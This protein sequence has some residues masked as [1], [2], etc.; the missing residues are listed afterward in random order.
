MD[1]R[2]TAGRLLVGLASLAIVGGCAAGSTP[3]ASLTPSPSPAPVAPTASPSPSPLD[4]PSP[5]PSAPARPISDLAWQDIGT[6]PAPGNEIQ[7]AAGF[8]R[9]Y[10]AVERGSSS[11]WFSADGRT[12]REVELPF[13]VTND[14]YGSPLEAGANA[15]TTNGTQVLVVGGYSHE[16][17]RAPEGASTGGGPDCPLYPIAWVSDDGVTWESADPG[18][19]PPEPS[20]YDQGSEF[21]AAWPVP[22]GGWDAALSF[23]EGES[24][25]GRDLW[26]SSDGIQWTEL[27]P[28]PAADLDSLLQFPMVHAGAADQAGRRVV[29]QVWFPGGAINAATTL[30]T[31]PDGLTWIS[32]ADVPGPGTDIRGGVAPDGVRSRWVLVG[33][34]GIGEDYSSSVPTVWTSEDRVSWAAAALPFVAGAGCAEDEEE[35]GGGIVTSVVLAQAGYVAVAAGWW[36]AQPYDTWLSEDGLTWVELPPVAGP[37]ASVGPG[38]VADGPAGVIGI[39]VGPTGSDEKA[40]V[41]QLR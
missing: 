25:T 30:A 38:V 23:W 39:G 27:E 36:G 37:G 10:V 4:T 8:A 20:G 31:S 40:A 11:V 26:H 7:S 34:S 32:V 28:A 35:C 41:W 5:A 16:P 33:G 9:G 12:W 18:P 14:E 21:V 17:C 13:K 6:I 24:L 15:V 2:T 29:W 1:V 19:M 22:T 3:S